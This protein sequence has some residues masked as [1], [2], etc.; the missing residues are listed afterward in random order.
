MRDPSLIFFFFSGILHE[1]AKVCEGRPILSKLQEIVLYFE[2]ILNY[3]VTVVCPEGTFKSKR[4]DWGLIIHYSYNTMAESTFP[5]NIDNE[6][7]PDSLDSPSLINPNS[8]LLNYEQDS[9]VL[10]ILQ[11]ETFLDMPDFQ[12]DLLDMP[13]FVNE[14]DQPSSGY[15]PVIPKPY[16]ISSTG[17]GA[18]SKNINKTISEEKMDNNNQIYSLSSLQGQ[19]AHTKNISRC[20]K[21]SDME[22][23]TFTGQGAHT[24]NISRC[25]SDSNMDDDDTGVQQKFNQQKFNQNSGDDDTGVQQK[26]NQ[27][28]CK[29]PE[30][31]LNFEVIPPP[32]EFALVVPK[33]IEEVTVENDEMD[34]SDDTDIDINVEFD[35]VMKELASSYGLREGGRN[36]KFYRKSLIAISKKEKDSLL[37]L[38]DKS[39]CKA[40]REQMVEMCE[41]NLNCMKMYEL[42]TLRIQSFLIKPFKFFTENL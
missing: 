32:V 40:R 21:D 12:N 16:V 7:V 14:T 28:S 36:K 27:N 29:V 2:K 3:P 25:F 6:K 13:D 5:Q 31:V 33:E 38:S 1:T 30:V 39:I 22:T 23:A 15:V 42:M 26:F 9:S 17:Q 11:N 24:K 34:E 19:G 4:E 18:Y 10:D 35:K 37:K 20:F 41:R 8:D